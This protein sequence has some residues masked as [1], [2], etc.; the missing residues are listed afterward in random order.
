[1]QRAVN[2]EVLFI[3]KM[4][5]SGKFHYR[6]TP[7]HD[8]PSTYSFV[9]YQYHEKDIKGIKNSRKLSSLDETHTFVYTRGILSVFFG[10]W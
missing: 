10:V 9:T 7:T 2:M 5:K 6:H 1:M 4:H 8:F 3:H